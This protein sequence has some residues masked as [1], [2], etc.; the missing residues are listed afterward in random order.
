MYQK[1]AYRDDFF[2]HRFE[3]VFSHFLDKYL[4]FEKKFMQNIQ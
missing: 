3:T 1:F 4:H 2:N